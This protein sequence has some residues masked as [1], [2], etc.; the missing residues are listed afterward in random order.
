MLLCSRR[1]QVQRIAI[2]GQKPNCVEPLGFCILRDLVP[3]NKAIFNINR[4]QPNSFVR[5][6]HL[7]LG[8][9]GVRRRAGAVGDCKAGEVVARE[10]GGCEKDCGR[11]GQ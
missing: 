6:R 7:C 9:A 10:R 8:A 5:R 2:H 3:L 11:C 1:R 4:T